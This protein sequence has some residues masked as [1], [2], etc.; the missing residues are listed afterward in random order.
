MDTS[1]APVDAPMEVL[2]LQGRDIGEPVVQRLGESNQDDHHELRACV[3]EGVGGGPGRLRSPGKNSLGRRPSLDK[4]PFGRS[5]W[6][7]VFVRPVWGSIVM[8]RRTDLG[9]AA[10]EPLNQL[11]KGLESWRESGELLPK[12]RKDWRGG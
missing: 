8:A 3:A 11:Q 9:G 4:D 6:F 1:F 7:Q 5:P 12:T 10:I 2:I